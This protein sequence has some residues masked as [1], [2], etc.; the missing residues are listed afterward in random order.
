MTA[1][2]R[3][4]CQSL[5]LGACPFLVVPRYNSV[6]KPFSWPR[7]SLI[8][9]PNHAG[10]DQDKLQSA[11]QRSFDS[12]YNS[13]STGKPF[14]PTFIT[15]LTWWFERGRARRV[16]FEIGP[17]LTG[18][19]EIKQIEVGNK[20]ELND[21]IGEGKTLST[22]LRAFAIVELASTEH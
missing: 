21:L 3:E 9:G 7:L 22:L 6:V 19:G 12:Y 14:P 15:H 18:V 1:R 8:A 10:P 4:L 13:F 20:E 16:C 11:V 5:I 17:P 2:R